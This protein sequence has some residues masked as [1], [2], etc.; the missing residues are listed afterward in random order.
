MTG[1]AAY[2]T[3]FR[4]WDPQLDREVALKL[5]SESKQADHAKV[6]VDEGRLLARVRHRG[7]VTVYGAARADG[8]AGLWM[9]LVEGRTL[10]EILQQQGRFSARGAALIGVAVCEAVRALR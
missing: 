6:V 3:V 1:N 4:A 10:E 8:Y 7:V 9:E 5:I 2:G